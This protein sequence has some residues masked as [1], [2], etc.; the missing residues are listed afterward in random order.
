MYEKTFPLVHAERG[1]EDTL[2]LTLMI[3]GEKRSKKVFRSKSG[4]WYFWERSEGSAYNRRC[5]H[6]NCFDT[7]SDVLAYMD[8]C[9]ADY[10][11]FQAVMMDDW[12]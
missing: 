11:L 6:F 3:P 7:D 12:I 8:R 1:A 2:S 10:C 4:R 5:I 9:H